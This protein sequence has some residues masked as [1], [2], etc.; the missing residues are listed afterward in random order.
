MACPLAFGEVGVKDRIKSVL[1][2]KKPAFWIILV[3]VVALVV[4]G[5]CFLTD[6]IKKLIDPPNV[7]TDKKDAVFSDIDYYE[8]TGELD[9]ESFITATNEYLS[10]NMQPVVYSLETVANSIEIKVDYSIFKSRTLVFGRIVGD[11]ATEFQNRSINSIEETEENSIYVD[12]GSY[13][14]FISGY[15]TWF[16]VVQVADLDLVN[17]NYY[18]RVDNNDC[19][20]DS[21]R[22]AKAAL[23]LISNRDLKYS[24]SVYA[25]VQQSHTPPELYINSKDLYRIDSGGAGMTKIG[26]LIQVDLKKANFDSSFVLGNTLGGGLTAE[27]LRKN[28]AMAWEIRRDAEDNNAD[29][30]PM[31][32]LYQK[33]KTV[34]CALGKTVNGQKTIY[35]VHGFEVTE[36]L[37]MRIQKEQHIYWAFS[38]Q[39]IMVLDEFPDLT[40]RCSLNAYVVDSWGDKYR[41]DGGSVKTAVFADLNQ[42]GYREFIISGEMSSKHDYIFVYDIK[43]EAKYALQAGYSFYLLA[44]ATTGG[45]TVLVFDIKNDTSLPESTI[46][47]T[48][49]GGSYILELCAGSEVWYQREHEK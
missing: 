46:R 43:N 35:A 41:L 26:S 5:V 22:D 32:L 23:R 21:S 14:T 39:P 17:H 8:W 25:G 38:N 15:D 34:L 48:K 7:D 11:A 40:F 6:P 10:A 9:E 42:D 45:L 29:M 44:N 28:N 13:L 20:T 31:Y 30:V 4:T 1:N 18:F 16:V 27:E 19:W 2:Y 12:I 36:G 33:D 47:M 3:A 37:H 24:H 49:S